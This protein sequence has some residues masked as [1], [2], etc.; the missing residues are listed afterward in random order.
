MLAVLLRDF[1]DRNNV[2]MVQLGRGLGFR[3]ETLD[4][5]TRGQSPGQNHFQRDD[6][7][8]AHLPRLED[9]SHPALRDLLQHS[10]RRSNEPF[11]LRIGRE[12]WTLIFNSV[13]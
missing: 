13:A 2:R 11:R 10:C 4:G 3:V 9:D 5:G 8:Q 6:P 1:I 7:F 12:R